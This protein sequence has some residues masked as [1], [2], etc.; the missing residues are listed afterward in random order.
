MNPFSKTFNKES[1]DQAFQTISDFL[2]KNLA[3]NQ[4]YNESDTL[5]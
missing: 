1:A 4:Y 3:D 2:E 5:Q